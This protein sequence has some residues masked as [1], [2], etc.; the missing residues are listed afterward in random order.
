MRIGL[1]IMTARAHDA[2][3]A[4]HPADSAGVRCKPP[5]QILGLAAAGPAMPARLRRQLTP[6]LMGVG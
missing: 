4:A 1:V 3:I 5:G 6:A 2:R